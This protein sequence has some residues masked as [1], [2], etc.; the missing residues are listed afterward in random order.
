MAKNCSNSP[1]SHI[2]ENTDVISQKGIKR[3][4]TVFG[5]EPDAK[6]HRGVRVVG[7]KR[8]NQ[9]EEARN[10]LKSLGQDEAKIVWEFAKTKTSQVG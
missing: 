7:G 8:P 9:Q 5:E 1:I 4:E 10:Y 3:S 6:R 2:V